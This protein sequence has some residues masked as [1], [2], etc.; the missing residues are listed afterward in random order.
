MKAVEVFRLIMLAS[1]LAVFGCTEATSPENASADSPSETPSAPAT[2]LQSIGSTLVE[3]TDWVL[4]AITD[5]AARDKMKGAIKQLAD[6]LVVNRNESAKADVT[7][8]RQT[9]ASLTGL[10]QALGPIGVALDQIDSEF[11]KAAE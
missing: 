8:I 9:L 10:G 2:P 11:E 5:D 7:A 6:D 4:V 3:A 1:V